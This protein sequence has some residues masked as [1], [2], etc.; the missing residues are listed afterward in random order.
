MP[1]RAS[2]Q[3]LADKLLN[4]TFGD[5]RDIVVFTLIGEVNY[6]TQTAEATETNNTKGIRIEYLKSQFGSSIQEGDY[7]VLVE[8]QSVTIDVRVDNVNMTFNGK[9]V[10]IVSVEEDAARAV[11]TLQIRDK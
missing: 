2:F 3:A 5:F 10:S 8:Q 1:T 6:D 7:M 9:N 4:N 11:Y